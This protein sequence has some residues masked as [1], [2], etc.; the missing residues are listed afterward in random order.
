MLLTTCLPQDQGAHSWRSPEL[1]GNKDSL[2][3]KAT[4]YHRVTDRDRDRDRGGLKAREI[5]P[6]DCGWDVS[7][8]KG[9]GDLPTNSGVPNMFLNSF[10]KSILWARPKSMIL[11]RGLGTFLSRSIMFSGLKKR[12]R[13]KSKRW[14]NAPSSSQNKQRTKTKHPNNDKQTNK[15]SKKQR[16][17]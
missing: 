7:E 2:A 14:Q 6:V 9:R 12:E 13:Q 8:P 17:G 5:Q 16:V 1:R 4:V 3:W 10:P 15:T 11:I